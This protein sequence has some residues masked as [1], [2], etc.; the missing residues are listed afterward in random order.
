MIYPRALRK[1]AP[2]L[3]EKDLTWESDELR[4]GAIDSRYAF[5]LNNRGGVVSPLIMKL[6]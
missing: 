3:A 2:F 4:K 5:G 1:S 6:T